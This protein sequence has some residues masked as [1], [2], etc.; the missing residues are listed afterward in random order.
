LS[1]V[2][3]QVGRVVPAEAAA[4]TPEHL[5]D[6]EFEHGLRLTGYDVSAN[7]AMYITLYWKL[8]AAQP[9][10]SNYTVFMHVVD[11]QGIPIMEPMDAPPL[12]GDWPTSAW[13]PGQTVADTR[14]IALPPNL[15]AG[16]YDVR[17]GFYDPAS[18]VRLT[19]WQ[20]DGTPWPDDAVVLAEVVAK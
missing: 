14:L 20:A 11:Q 13:L 3:F 4:A 1:S 19:A 18:G 10:P 9:V 15:H 7:G 16:Q 5:V 8:D 17:V 6:S 12:D 2:T